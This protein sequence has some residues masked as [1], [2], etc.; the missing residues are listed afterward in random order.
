MR[1]PITAVINSIC[2]RMS[3]PFGRTPM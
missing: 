3:H 1:L 2:G